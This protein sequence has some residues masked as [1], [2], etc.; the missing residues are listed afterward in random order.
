MSDYEVRAAQA[1]QRFTTLL[2]YAE[3]DGKHVTVTR[4]GHPVAV[5]V[6]ASW[7]RQALA[8]EPLTVENP[9]RPLDGDMRFTAGTDL[10]FQILAEVF[11]RG[12]DRR[13][14][15]NA[16]LVEAVSA[17]LDRPADQPSAPEA[18]EE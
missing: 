2:A 3:R 14:A 7:Y 8:A 12:G 1:R 9:A 6:P 16:F 11:R 4:Y 17:Y 18:G 15:L 5:L 13:E 10:S